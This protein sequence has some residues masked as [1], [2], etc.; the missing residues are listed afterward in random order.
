MLAKGT[1][2]EFATQI[3]SKIEE[4][5]QHHEAKPSHWSSS[6]PSLHDQTISP[7]TQQVNVLDVD[8]AELGRQLT[9]LQASAFERLRPR[10]YIYWMR[11]ELSMGD[12][13][14]R[15]KLLD[16]AINRKMGNLVDVIA[17]FVGSVRWLRRELRE[18]DDVPALLRYLFA[19][20][21][22]HPFHSAH[23][24]LCVLWCG[25]PVILTDV[26]AD[27][28]KQELFRVGNLMG[29]AALVL[30]LSP[31]FNALQSV[32]VHYLTMSGFDGQANWR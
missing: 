3:L 17:R 18:A 16:S 27:I 15:H 4:S 8:P 11:S 19:V 24:V 6:R 31:H 30:V 5:R 10:E 9:L 23:C 2:D 12:L 26:A 22:V 7:S 13:V 29:L 32:S 25:R 1:G 20:A 28:V 14:F 21:R